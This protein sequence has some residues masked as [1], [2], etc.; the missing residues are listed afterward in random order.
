MLKFNFYGLALGLIIYGF[1]GMQAEAA[2]DCVEV[3]KACLFH[4]TK[5]SGLRP[6]EK[7]ECKDF[8]EAIKGV[9]NGESGGQSPS[10]FP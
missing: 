3:E 4:C 7:K 10:T 2:G 6:G 9:C 5:P 8:C 1:S